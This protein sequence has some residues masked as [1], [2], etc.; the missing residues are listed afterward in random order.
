MNLTFLD[1]W[2]RMS[3]DEQEKFLNHQQTAAKVRRQIR[4][5][6]L[7]I[8]SAQE[9]IHS[10]QTEVCEHPFVIKTPRADTGNYDRS[11]DHYWYDC[12]CPDCENTWMENQ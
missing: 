7:D 12:K 4:A 9:T 5:L 1:M 3:L 6:K 8:E 10:I 2:N 11:Q